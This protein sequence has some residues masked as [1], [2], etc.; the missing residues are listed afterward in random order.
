MAKSKTTGFKWNYTESEIIARKGF[1]SRLNR[2]FA[3]ISLEHMQKYIPYDPQRAEGVH[4]SDNTTISSN[5]EYA[6]ISFDA[7]YARKQYYLTNHP[8]SDHSPLAT[9]QWDKYCWQLEKG[10]ILAE[11]GLWEEAYSK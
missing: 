3:E 5:Y 6:S 11:V 4:M 10:E 9:D 2:K 8:M 1:G 7:P